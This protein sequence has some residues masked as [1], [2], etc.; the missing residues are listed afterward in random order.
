MCR[1]VARSEG[2]CVPSR[3]TTEW[4]FRVFSASAQCA[5]KGKAAAADGDGVAVPQEVLSRAAALLSRLSQDSSC[6]TKLRE[7]R[8]GCGV[9]NGT[10]NTLLTRGCV[11]RLAWCGAL[12]ASFPR[13]LP[14]QTRLSVTPW[15][16]SSLLPLWWV[17]YSW[18]RTD[19]AVDWDNIACVVCTWQSHE[20]CE[21]FVSM[22]GLEATAGM[23]QSVISACKDVQA[24]RLPS[25]G[26]AEKVLISVITLRK[27]VCVPRLLI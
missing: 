25:V 12:R 17:K 4:R 2:A 3:S 8:A 27:L 23:I 11:S 24:S 19:H 18:L 20:A 22:G 5:A 9:A 26:N 13:L 7:V 15:F 14:R 1:H 16:G 21:A 10:V 6:C